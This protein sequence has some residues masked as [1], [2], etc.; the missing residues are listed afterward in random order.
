[1]IY[2]SSSTMDGRRFASEFAR[3]RKED[4]KGVSSFG[5]P[6]LTKAGVSSKPPQESFKVVQKK[7]K[8]V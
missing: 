8:R 1:M 4:A 7:K 2:A 5:I 3:K 6:D